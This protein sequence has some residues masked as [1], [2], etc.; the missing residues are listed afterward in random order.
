V[1][2]PLAMLCIDYLQRRRAFIENIP[3]FALSALFAAIGFAGQQPK[4]AMN[5]AP[6]VCQTFL[7]YLG[8]IFF[9]IR[10]NAIYL[11]PNR[12]WWWCVPAA[13]AIVVIAFATRITA[14][15]MLF[16]VATIII[17]LPFV[18][19]SDTVAADRFT[20][21]P[22]IGIAYAVAC[23]T[24]PKAWPLVGIIAAI[25]GVLAF[26]RSRVW[27]DSISL[28]NSVIAADPHIAQ[29]YNGRAVALFARG[30]LDDAKRD[31]DRALAI[32]PC[33][34]PALRNQIVLG[35]GQAA[36]DKLAK[37]QK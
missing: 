3:F 27:H 16:F 13:I 18:T 12:I 6:L 26:E 9:P 28:W 32:D 2:F 36:R 1:T 19:W 11:Y 4:A 8:K 31:I 35:G 33:Y 21:I 15:A 24:K 5:G 7:F 22:S 23:L 20:Y 17:V 25:L 14:F 30:D 29:A 10:L 37:C 34:A